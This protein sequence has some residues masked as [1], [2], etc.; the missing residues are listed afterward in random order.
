MHLLHATLK[1]K[2][3]KNKILGMLLLNLDCG[4]L[5]NPASRS[6]GLIPPPPHPHG[7]SIFL[8]PSRSPCDLAL[9]R[10]V[11]SQTA[12]GS[13]LLK[14]WAWAWRGAIILSA[15][16]KQ[17]FDTYSACVTTVVPYLER[18]EMRLSKS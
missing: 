14:A 4:N 2:S 18:T 3:K 13:P 15:Q 16:T 10:T 5:G 12:S 8:I 17:I 9:K 11:C 6:E 1:F 7:H